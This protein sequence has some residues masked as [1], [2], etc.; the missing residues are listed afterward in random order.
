MAGGRSNVNP[1]SDHGNATRAKDRHS[2]PED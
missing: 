2:F 1:A